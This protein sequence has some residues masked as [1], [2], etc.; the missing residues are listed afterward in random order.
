MGHIFREIDRESS[1]GRV[2]VL[3]MSMQRPDKKKKKNSLVKSNRLRSM[4]IE[5]SH[6][7]AVNRVKFNFSIMDPCLKGN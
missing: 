1:F 4:P 3:N 7:F 5:S 6:L 2:R